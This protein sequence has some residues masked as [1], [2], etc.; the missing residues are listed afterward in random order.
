LKGI[1]KNE[2]SDLSRLGR[3]NDKKPLEF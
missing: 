2:K 1:T 3:F